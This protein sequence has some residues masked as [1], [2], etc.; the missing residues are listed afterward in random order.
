MR[1]DPNVSNAVA[2]TAT[3]LDVTKPAPAALRR[4]PNPRPASIVT[5]SSLGTALADEPTSPRTTA[6][7]ERIRA[8][9]DAGEYPIDLDQ[10]AQRIVDD[11][12]LRE[13]GKP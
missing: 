1:I 9:L 2:I 3:T 7:L 6:R 13:G 5:L 12:V 11:D 4:Q 8:L 10:L